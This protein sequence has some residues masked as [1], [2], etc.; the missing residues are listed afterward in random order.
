MDS[1]P[2]KPIELPSAVPES[3]NPFI[4]ALMTIVDVAMTIYGLWA[5]YQQDRTI[6]SLI[7]FAE[8]EPIEN[9]KL[10]HL[11]Q[12]ST[13]QALV[14]QEFKDLQ[15]KTSSLRELLALVADLPAGDPSVPSYLA[16]ITVVAFTRPL[17]EDLAESVRAHEGALED[18]EALLVIDVALMINI[19]SIVSTATL[20]L[21]ALSP[22]AAAALPDAVRMYSS[23]AFRAAMK[24]HVLATAELAMN[25][26]RSRNNRRF[27]IVAKPIGEPIEGGG[28]ML[29]Y[30]YTFEGQW[31]ADRDDEGYPGR[32]NDAVIAVVKEKMRAHQVRVLP[33]FP[34]V[35]EIARMVDA[36]R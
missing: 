10:L 32:N 36:L 9:Q 7:D 5:E 3:T 16:S 23:E 30:G 8:R 17:G 15:G 14:H 24:E 18:V 19:H 1:T 26:L 20:H 12:I 11:S 2:E 35:A 25:I 34:G 21:D 4:G 29:V 13:A 27:A 6:Q 22:D 28:R 31:Y 33:R